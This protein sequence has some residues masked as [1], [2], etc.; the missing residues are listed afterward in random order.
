MQRL[1]RLMNR[2][3]RGGPVRLGLLGAVAVGIALAGAFLFAQLF[4]QGARSSAPTPTH[5]L[6]VGSLAPDFELPDVTTGRPV[7]LS[8]L[9]G[10]PVWVNFWA[11]WCPP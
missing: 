7:R 8:S 4:I 2:P 5:E 10:R 3:I 6:T 11:T 9:R 1:T